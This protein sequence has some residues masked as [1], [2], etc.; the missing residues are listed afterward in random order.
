MGDIW[1]IRHG[2]SEWNAA[3]RWQGQADPPL[4]ALG[5]AQ[6]RAL[7][8]ALAPL[9]RERS[10]VLAA[11]DLSRARETAETLGAALGLAVRL[12]ARLRE[13]DVGEWSGHTPA[14]VERRWPAELARFRAGDDRFPAGGGET[15]LALR[16]RVGAALAELEASGAETIALVSHLGVVRAFRPGTALAP[17]A[18][19]RLESLAEPAPPGHNRP[20][21]TVAL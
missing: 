11:S 16:A 10:V 7:V 12:D 13:L 6:A 1:F 4:S 5:R 21:D 14:E 17:G 18:W 2:E 19:L 3:G 15:R 20:P 8:A 9:A